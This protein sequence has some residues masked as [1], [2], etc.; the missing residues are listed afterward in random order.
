MRLLDG[1]DQAQFDA[2]T[3]PAAPLCILAGPGSGKTRV[4]TRRIAYRIQ[5][6]QAEPA[7]TLAVTF[8][9]RAAVELRTRLAHLGVGPSEGVAVGTLHS[10][11]YAHLRQY[12]DDRGKRTPRIIDNSRRGLTDEE[13]R[14]RGVIDFEDVLTLFADTVR[15]D[16][17]FAEAVRW[18]RRH[19]YVDEFQDVTPAQFD[20]VMAWVG[21]G[22]DLCVVGDPDQS[23]YGWSG[24]DPDLMASLPQRFPSLHVV[25]LDANYRSSRAIVHAAEAVLGR[26]TSTTTTDDAIGGAVTTVPTLAGYATEAD[27]AVA[28]ARQVR[29]AHAP[30]TAWS[31]VAVLARTNARLDLVADALRAAA[32]PVHI[33]GRT[34]LLARPA[35]RDGLGRL[36]PGAAASDE[37]CHLRALAHDYSDPADQ[38]ALH[39]VADMAAQFDALSP[40]GSAAAF[41]DWLPTTRAG[42]PAASSDAVVL[43]TFHKAKGLEWQTVFVVGANPGLVPLD[44]GD[45]DEERR[46]LYVAMTRAERTLHVSYVG[47]PSPFLPAGFRAAAPAE[48]SDDTASPKDELARMRIRLAQIDGPV[49]AP[50]RRRPA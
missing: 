2:V 11:A 1:L 25:R 14:R 47:E 23:I 12:W 39:E 6:G 30:N 44:S 45:P 50:R 38:Q 15:A 9:R 13:K 5:S 41:I 22:T 21:Q 24:A 49:M 18:F 17:G 35:V 34:P 4:L 37:A 20:A 19:I 7:R 32:I 16:A 46:L 31:R 40:G 10:L 42:D 3:S 27:E 48:P 36:H 8:A 26:T 29:L 33:A 28:V 43:A